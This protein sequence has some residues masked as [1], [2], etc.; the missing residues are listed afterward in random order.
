MTTPQL[1]NSNPR[2]ERHKHNIR[3]ELKSTPTWRLPENRRV[4]RGN[5]DQGIK[6]QNL[7]AL[8]PKHGFKFKI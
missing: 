8:L 3:T 5:Q 2:Q 6:W 1:K 7:L 4:E